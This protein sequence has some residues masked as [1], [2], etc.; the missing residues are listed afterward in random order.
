MSVNTEDNRLIKY[1]DEIYVPRE[2]EFR[3]Y[4]FSL[5]MSRYEGHYHNTFFIHTIFNEEED[6]RNLMD[7]LI[8]HL[9]M[10][11]EKFNTNWNIQQ[12]KKNGIDG[13]VISGRLAFYL[14]RAL[15]TSGIPPLMNLLVL[16]EEW[17][18]NGNDIDEQS[19]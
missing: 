19:L 2:D 7:V 3:P 8:P 6:R 5:I 11:D 17:K 12:S 15:I 14:Q 1:R 13:V 16:S 18:N 10:L 4:Y 9:Q